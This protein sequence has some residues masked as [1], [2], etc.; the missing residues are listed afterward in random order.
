VGVEEKLRVM[1]GIGFVVIVE[2]DT[3]VRM[4]G[5]RNLR[6]I[7][8]AMVVVAV[9]RLNLSRFVVA[10]TCGTTTDNHVQST[11][12]SQALSSLLPCG[13]SIMIFDEETY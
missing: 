8:T 12:P 6:S 5:I 10:R 3:G 1:E 9:Y 7:E 11:I 4:D 2:N 13:T